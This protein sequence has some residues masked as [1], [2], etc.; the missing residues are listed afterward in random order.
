MK[1]KENL[2]PSLGPSHAKRPGYVDGLIGL[3]VTRQKFRSITKDS[4]WRN[5]QDLV[6]KE[7]LDTV[8]IRE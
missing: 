8:V 6:I 1:H 3:S 4:R 2:R 5:L 7:R